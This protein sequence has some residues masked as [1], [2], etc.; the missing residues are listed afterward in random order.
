MDPNEKLRRRPD[1]HADFDAAS[2]A[3]AVQLMQS[4]LQDELDRKEGDE[5]DEALAQLRLDI[6]SV[7]KR[8]R[9]WAKQRG[10]V[11]ALPEPPAESA[12]PAECVHCLQ[13]LAGTLHDL[14][15]RG[16][17]AQT[18]PSSTDETLR[19]LLEILPSLQGLDGMLRELRADIAT[20]LLNERDSKQLAALC[21]VEERSAGA[22]A[23]SAEI[24]TAFRNVCHVLK[25]WD[26]T[27]ASSA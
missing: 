2:V 25:V 18:L 17:E 8:I 23:A 21:A 15:Y 6:A 4:E 26:L 7:T 22:C 10:I 14:G 9:S 13:R 19:A 12:S 1:A 16:V 27:G 3:A 24:V 5:A 11:A 20:I